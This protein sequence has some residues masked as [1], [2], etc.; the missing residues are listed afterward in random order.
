[1]DH[2]WTKGLKG[3]AK[4]KRVKEVLSYRNAFDALSELLTK[5]FK[6]FVPDYSNPS[7]AHEQADVNG[8]NRKLSSIIKLITIEDKN[9]S[10]R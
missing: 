5:E 10:I 1:M 4:E 2:R 9:E 3:E 6:E 7:W 8:A